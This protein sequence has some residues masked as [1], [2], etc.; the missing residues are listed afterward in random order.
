MRVDFY[1]LSQD[2][3]EDV[4]P[5][6]ARATLQAGERMLVVAQ[7]ADL[8]AGIDRAL[9]AAHPEAFLAHG[10]A[11]TSHAARQPILL[12][13]DCTPDNG[14]RYCVLADGVWRDEAAEFARV[15]LVFG[16]DR[17]EET[18]GVWR[19]F[20]AVEGAQRHFWKQEGGKWR[21]GP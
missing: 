18:R 4:V 13:S 9:W 10:E 6:L 5:L 12:A 15:F 14:A 20:D 1:Q 19:K 8:R 11:G 21:E 3:P 7:D 16:D 17:L 2:G